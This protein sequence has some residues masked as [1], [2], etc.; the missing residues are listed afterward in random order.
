ML[1]RFRERFGTAGVIV[2]VIALVAAL[3]GTALAASGALTGKQK[4]EVE[5]IAKKFQGT[6]PAGAQGPAGPAGAKGDTG[7][8]GDAGSPGAKGESVTGTPI[9]AGGTCGASVTGVKY[10]LGATSTN[11]CNGKQGEPG[12][13]VEQVPSGKLLTGTWSASAVASGTNPGVDVTPISFQFPL[14]S[15]PTAYYL[16]PGVPFAFEVQPDG[17]HN[18]PVSGTT[19]SEACPG[20]AEAPDAATGKLCVYVSSQEEMG[21]YFAIEGESLE[22]FSPTKYGTRLAFITESAES[23]QDANIAGTWAARGT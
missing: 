12:P 22:L 1:T 6:G 19:L 21:Y 23:S 7:D 8:K 3:G 14:A 18:F 13:L 11:V 17:T 4:K 2:A 5:K 20:T 9:A 16:I 15:A 10:T